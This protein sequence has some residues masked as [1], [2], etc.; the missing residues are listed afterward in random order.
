MTSKSEK[1]ELEARLADM[2]ARHRSLDEAIEIMDSAPGSDQLNLQ[3]LK[4]EK[5][6]LKDEIIRIEAI[7]VPDIIA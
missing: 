7:L 6:A 3:R 2:Q 5:L 1:S 4:K